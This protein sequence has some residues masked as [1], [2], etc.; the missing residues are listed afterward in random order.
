M[1]TKSLDHA[2]KILR[3]HVYRR[4][5]D[6]FSELS[7]PEG[8]CAIVTKTV[9]EIVEPIRR[10]LNT[11]YNIKPDII[12]NTLLREDG[13]ITGLDYTKPVLTVYDKASYLNE[14]LDTKPSVNHAVVLGDTSED[15]GMFD[16]ARKRYGEKNTLTVALHPKDRLIQESADCMVTNIPAFYSYVKAMSSEEPIPSVMDEKILEGIGEPL[17]NYKPHN[18]IKEEYTT[19]F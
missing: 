10:L 12:A 17:I 8:T 1:P 19:T 15:L 6:L 5:L 13:Y 14:L 18:T 3:Y 9:H 4:S 7:D 11:K 16:A 2:S